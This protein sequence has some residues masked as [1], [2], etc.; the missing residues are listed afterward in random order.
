MEMVASKQ[1]LQSVLLQCSTSA[2]LT[3]AHARIILHNQEVSVF[4]INRKFLLDSTSVS[5]EYQ[6]QFSSDV[7]QC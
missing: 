3:P 2:V 1:A 6:V 5:C 4:T 7:I